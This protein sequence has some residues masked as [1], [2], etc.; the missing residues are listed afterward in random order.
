MTTPPTTQDRTC[1]EPATLQSGVYDLT[2]SLDIDGCGSVTATT[3]P[4][5][6][7]LRKSGN[8]WFYRDPTSTT[9]FSQGSY[10]GTL[11]EFGSPFSHTRDIDLCSIY[12]TRTTDLSVDERD[13]ESIAGTLIYHFAAVPKA[14]VAC[15]EPCSQRWILSG[16]LR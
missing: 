1:D 4:L 6:I 5:V 13:S 3:E 9:S 15:P 12:E 2:A 8:L 16:H 10:L 7:E 11:F 14:V